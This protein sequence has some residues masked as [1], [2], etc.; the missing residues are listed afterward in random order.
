[1]RRLA[2]AATLLACLVT[3]PAE[4]ATLVDRGGRLIYTAQGA[5]PVSVSFSYGQFGT[6]TVIPQPSNG[7]PVT[8]TGCTT[9]TDTFISFSCPGVTAIT[10]TGGSGDDTFYTGD[11]VVPFTADGG[12]GDDQLEGGSAADTLSGGAGD[13]Y[14]YGETGDTVA[15]GPGTDHA[16]YTPPADRLG[17][18][19]ITLDGVADDGVE[20][21]RVNFAADIEEIESDARYEYSDTPLATY[22]PVTIVGTASANRLTGSSGPDTITGGGGIDVLEGMA[23]D[24]TLLA[25]DG[26]ADRVHC[27]PG[28]DTAV[29]D[30]I[31]QV[32]DTCE[33]VRVAAGE[34]APIPVAA[35]DDTPPRISWRP[36]SPLGILADDDHG[37]AQVQWFDDDRLICTATTAPFDC[38]Y[39]PRFDDVGANTITAIATDGA[40]QTASVVT[41]R[42][43]E[44][45]KPLAISLRVKRT[46]RRYVA[47]GSVTLPSGVPCSG[48]VAVG[49]RTGKL[50]RACTF[51]IAVPRHAKYVATYRGT[52]AIASVHSK[53]VRSRA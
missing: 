27:G 38:D 1:M 14:L 37:I 46:G 33:V 28:N 12:A 49:T 52:D 13:D 40:G 2:L 34:T 35:P 29:V 20:G 17:P 21:D 10:A 32:S 41:T 11:L 36:G 48:T 47:T 30:P 18:V 22:G 23:G 31:D 6:V 9:S 19:N 4:A 50:S 53:A 26:L 51:R 24:D 25:R 42:T 5:A 44:R 43:V 7:D 39:R 8:A 16:F 3:A 15:G 45:F